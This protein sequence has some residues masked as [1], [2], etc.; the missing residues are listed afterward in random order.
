[1]AITAPT[2]TGDFSGFLNRNQ[3]QPIFDEVRRQSVVQQLARQVPLGINGEAIPVVTGKVTAGWVAEGAP[4]PASEGTR[5]L[6]NMDPK[7][8]A[9]IAVVSAEVVRANPA[10]Y[11]DDIRADIA[12]AMATAFDAAALYGTNSP[13]AAD[14]ADTTKSVEFTAAVY[15]NLVAALTLLVNDGKALTG[16][17]LGLKTEP[18]MLGVKDTTGRPIFIE[19]PPTE[20]VVDNQLR[21]RIFGRPAILDEAADSGTNRGFAGDWSQIA[22]GQVGGINYDVSTEASVTIDGALVSLWE[23]N[24]VAIR[25]E[26]EFGLVI[27][28]VAAFVEFTDAA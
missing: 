6:V 17:A 26:T 5:A 14:L 13:F 7:K 22:W 4:K 15:D 25:A 3:A 18:L 20:T 21:G 23:N 28:D 2:L 12:E 16:W 27:N 9:A 24:L 19:A 1:M 11:M 8:I 10:G